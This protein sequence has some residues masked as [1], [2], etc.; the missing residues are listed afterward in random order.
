VDDS[1]GDSP[2]NRL[3]LSSPITAALMA[4]STCA[5]MHIMVGSDGVYETFANGVVVDIVESLDAVD[6]V[7]G[8][9][10]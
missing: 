8:R 6:E 3:G 4:V 7:V 5:A 1:G 10:K 2:I 9:R